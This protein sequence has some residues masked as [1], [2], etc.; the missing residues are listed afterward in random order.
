[1]TRTPARTSTQKPNQVRKIN[2]FTSYDL[3]LADMNTFI[4]KHLPLLH[5]DDHLKTSFPTESFNRRNKNLKDLLSLSLFTTPRRKK[6][7]CVTSCNTCG[8]CK[9]YIVFS[10]TFVCN[11]TGKKYFIGDNLTCNSTNGIYL[12]ECINCK[13]QYVGSAISFKQFFRIH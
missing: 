4:K 1:M 7:G 6:Y 8:N 9:N 3:S 12:V 2:L 5:S 11:V 13:C 10:S